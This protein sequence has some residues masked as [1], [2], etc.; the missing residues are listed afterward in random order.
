MDIKL[1]KIIQEKDLDFLLVVLPSNI[2]YFTKFLSNP[3]E[4]V[5]MLCYDKNDKKYLLLPK[6][7]LEEAKKSIKEDIEY[8]PY[9]DTENPFELLKNKLNENSINTD[10]LGIDKENISLKKYEDLKNILNI[11]NTHAIDEDIK[12]Y[13][14]Y[15]DEKEIENLQEAAKLAD[16]CIE[17]AKNNLKLGM[18][19]LELKFIIE[20]EIKKYGVN[21][22]SFE[23]IVLF[24]ENAAKPHGVSGN[25]KLKENDLILLDLGCYYNNYASDITRCLFFGNINEEYKKIYDIV[26]KANVEAIKACKIGKSFAEIDKVARDVIS[27]A[28]YGKYFVHRLGHG[29]GLDCHEYPD[30]SSKNTNLKLQ[31][32][33]VF[34]IEPGIY[35][36]DFIGVRIEDDILITKEGARVFT[37]YDK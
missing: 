6:L 17:I 23:T 14:L 16:K 28:G 12:M 24:S 20:N 37:K 34:T 36:P 2:F 1:N 27:D 26:L 5:L 33:M 10:K 29:L 35:I 19:E 15:K 30:V 21:K 11:K 7:D 18:T 8:I 3:H 4:R 22:M 13:R 9:L 31:E 32:G 25:R